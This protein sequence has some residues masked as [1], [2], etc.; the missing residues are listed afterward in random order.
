[1]EAKFCPIFMENSKTLSSSSILLYILL[2]IPTSDVISMRQMLY[3]VVA[4][5]G[6]FIKA[7]WVVMV[8][9]LLQVQTSSFTAA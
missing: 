3:A 7:F 1:M 8:L 6:S 9:F 4:S 2:Q 5:S